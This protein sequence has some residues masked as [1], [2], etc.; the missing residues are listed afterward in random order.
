M[1]IHSLTLDSRD[2]AAQKDFYTE[3]LGF[4]L[5]SETQDSVR[6]K[7][8]K[9]ELTF[10]KSDSDQLY[11]FAFMI[12]TTSLEECI[13][14]VEGLGVELLPFKGEKVIHFDRGR[15][16]Y[17]HDSDGN[18]AEFI[19][20]PNAIREKGG[21]FQISEV[22]RL[23]EIGLPSKDALR[24]ADQLIQDYGIVP[25]AKQR[26]DDEFCWVGDFEGVILVP[27]LGRPWLPTGQPAVTNSFKIE[28]STPKGR[29][30][31]EF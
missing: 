12:P 5:I 28:F 2:L 21:P 27:K 3:R 6:I 1:L 11:H 4:K 16:I 31:V 26:F 19:E 17:F 15:A 20:R 30:M 23:N 18:I 22:V 8:G 24:R 29:F 7:I 10:Q 9:T 25:I 13:E 14:F